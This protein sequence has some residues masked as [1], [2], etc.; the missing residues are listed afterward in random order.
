MAINE[1]GALVVAHDRW[2]RE[3][4]AGTL[5][6][7]GFTVQQASN[8]VSALRIV[9]RDVPQ[10]VVIGEDLSELS[11]ADLANSIQSDPRTRHAA[12]VEVGS[13][14]ASTPVELLAAV[15]S[16]LESRYADPAAMPTRSVS[17]SPWGTWPL[18][19]AALSHSSSRT[20]NAG[21]SG[22]L[23]LSSGIETL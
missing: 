9:G 1:L 5:E 13:D 15:V 6:E 19:S 2:T 14:G 18:V 8:G 17:A 11:A 23:R 7:A 22:K 12:L 3:S 21:R 4:V 10:I 20:R 16:A